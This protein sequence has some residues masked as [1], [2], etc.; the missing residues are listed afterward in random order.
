MWISK[1]PAI[2][3]AGTTITWRDDDTTVPFDQHATSTDWTLKY[4][5]RSSVA[6]AHTATATAYNS[7][8]QVTISATDSAGFVE[9]DWS[10][11]AVI[12]K[13]SEKFRLGEGTIKV[14]QSLSYTGTTPGVLETRSQNKIDRDNIKA[15]LRKFQ[16]G[17][18]E[19]SIAGR[20]FKRSNIADLQSELDRLNAIVMREDIAEKVAQGQGNPSR[21]FV[22]F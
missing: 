7:G 4:Y 18:Q 19:Y 5:L 21:F 3:A 2:V 20:T 14:K 17:M 13:G 15:A 6:G 10:Y 16:D 8:W 9:G 11:E 1:I 22:R 12:S